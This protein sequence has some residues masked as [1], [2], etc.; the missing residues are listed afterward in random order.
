[1]VGLQNITDHV[2]V[3]CDGSADSA[4][5]AHDLALAVAHRTDAVEGALYPGTVVTPKIANSLFCS[6]QVFPRHLI[7]TQQFRA[8]VAKEAGLRSTA[9][10]QDDFQES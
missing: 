1:M 4:S 5:E 7:L 6:R 3:A 10:I 2:H 9:N 8:E